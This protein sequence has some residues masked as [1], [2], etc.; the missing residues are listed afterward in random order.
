MWIDSGI[1]PDGNLGLNTMQTS[2][3]NDQVTTLL[4]NAGIHFSITANGTGL[5]R[6]NWKCDGWILRLHKN[7]NTQMFDYFTDIGHRKYPKGFIVD[8]TL[9]PCCIAYYKQEKNKKP[10]TPDVCDIIHSLNIDSQAMNESFC[11]WCDNF[12]YDSDSIAAL[13]VY[14]K[15]CDTAKKYHSI[16]DRSI[17]DALEVILQDY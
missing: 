6:D 14:N 2:T 13:N 17:R 16:I 8:K 7:N 10:V 3:V 9:N 5:K 1:F 12:G 11:N 4:N 15:C